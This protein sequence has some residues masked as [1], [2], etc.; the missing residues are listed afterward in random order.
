MRTRQNR[1]KETAGIWQEEELRQRKMADGENNHRASR[2][3]RKATALRMRSFGRLR[4]TLAVIVIIWLALL[5]RLYQIQIL[6][7]GELQLAATSQY[8]VTVEGLDTRG[9]ILDRNYEPLTDGADQ[10]YYFLSAA[11]EDKGS[12]RL[13]T[14]I[15]A[16]KVSD[17]KRYKVYRSQMFD[18]T[19]NQRLKDEYNA[20]VFR[21]PTRYKDEQIACHL[22]GYLNQ[23]E[24][25]GV[26]GLEL[27]C[28]PALKAGGGKLTLWADSGGGLLLGMAPKQE[29]ANE[30]KVSSIV[31]TLDTGI[32]KCCE[33]ALKATGLDGAVL[34]S[35]ASSGQVLGWASSPIFNPNQ[36]DS[37]LASGGNCL[38]DKCIQGGYAPG[39]VF[40]LVVAAAALE[41]RELDTRRLLSARYECEGTTVVEGI[42]L[43]CQA[44]PAGGHGKVNMY[45]AMAKSCNCYFA[46]LGDELGYEAIYQMAQ[47][48]G[49]GQIVFRKGGTSEGMFT[50]EAVGNLPSLQETGPWDISNLS[51]G[52]GSILTTPAQIQRMMSIIANNGIEAGLHVIQ[53]EETR[54]NRILS[55]N[56]AK[57][58]QKMLSKVMTEGTGSGIHVSCPVYGK[59]GT[60]ETGNSQ[61]TGQA[62]SNCWFSGYCQIKDRN[63]VVTVMVE[64]G[65]SGSASALPVFQQLCEYLSMRNFK[66]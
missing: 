31:T 22:I 47:R 4:L 2:S 58:L 52:Q 66:L 34:V 11:R 65:R 16:R 54:E 57:T 19:V 24:Q 43:G 26:S 5:A 25:R 8:Q 23:S 32:Q 46:H 36:V 40:K 1:K 38:V 64:N 10:Y 49:F 63:Y 42:K 13:L 28:E 12:E 18:E 62:I 35:E 15:S 17:G 3:G 6:S 51:I 39:S 56:T 14:G 60:A 55:E 48:F 21:C 44:G 59:T 50:E 30:M 61:E 29:D 37:Y 33:E 45:E 20:Y 9:P 7:H 53:G 27:A 41:S